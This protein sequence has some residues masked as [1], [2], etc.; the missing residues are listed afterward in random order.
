MKFFK[1]L[2]KANLNKNAI[3]DYHNEKI[4]PDLRPLGKN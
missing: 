1:N 3:C 4:L 2:F